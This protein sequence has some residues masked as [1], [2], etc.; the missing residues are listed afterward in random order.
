MPPLSREQHEERFTRLIDYRHSASGH[1]TPQEDPRGIA[2]AVLDLRD[3][4]H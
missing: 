1:N 3:A 2:A 4:L